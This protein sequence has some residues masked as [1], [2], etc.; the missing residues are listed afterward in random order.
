LRHGYLMP[1]IFRP[2]DLAMMNLNPK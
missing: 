2:R 1:R